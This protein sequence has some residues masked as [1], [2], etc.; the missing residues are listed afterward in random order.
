MRRLSPRHL[1]M[2]LTIARTGSLSRTAEHMATTQPGLSKWLRELEAALGVP[3]FE[4][5][6]RKLSATPF[7]EI[8][9]RHAERVLGDAD[10]TQEEI[11]ALRQG[12]LGRLQLG[13][14]P[15]LGAPLMPGAIRRLQAQGV[16]LDVHLRENTLDV[17]LPLLKEH[18]LDL[19]VARLD[20]A[21]RNAGVNM[22]PL[23]SERACIMACV[24]HPLQRRRSLTW[25]D[26]AGQPWVLPVAGSPMRDLLDN[27]F[28]Q[29][30]LAIPR[31]LMESA[32]ALTNRA[33]AQQL[34]CLFLTSQHGAQVFESDGSLR[35]LPLSLGAA[36]T[37]IGVLWAVETLA[38]QQRHMMDA[39]IA[40][41]AEI[42]G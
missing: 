18:K 37:E 29:A 6:T 17:M 2:L 1:E 3:L 13:I 14:L 23:L 35:R 26:A 38:P 21:A 5:T 28:T 15:G 41:A 7:G 40:T 36:P 39:L 27:A 31:P 24:N 32:S 16:T 42:T 34:G 19:L 22:Q 25:A 8:V 12:R 9:L 11:Q 10:R 33:M 30:G 20:R 4:R